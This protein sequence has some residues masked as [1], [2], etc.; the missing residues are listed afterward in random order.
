MASIDNSGGRGIGGDVGD[1]LGVL[2][3]QARS[4]APTGDGD[5]GAQA[6]ATERDVLSLSS[7]AVARQRQLESGTFERNIDEERA[8]LLVLQVQQSIATQEPGSLTG[9][10]NES[11]RL[12]SFLR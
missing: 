6:S 4:V 8:S 1:T 5:R 9:S 2:R 3:E 7:E 12:I 10:S 11:R